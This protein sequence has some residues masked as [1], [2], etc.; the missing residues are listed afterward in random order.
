MLNSPLCP[1]ETGGILGGTNGVI[2]H[3]V[4]DRGFGDYDQYIPD[5]ELLNRIIIQ[6]AERN[7]SLMGIYHTHFVGC[8]ELSNGD[9]RYI[10]RI[11]DSA[12]EGSILYFPIVIPNKSVIAYRA[13]KKG[14]LSI[15]FN[16]IKTI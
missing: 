6:W 2:N 7:I 5:T 8:T 16:K 3:I 10:S 12:G 9:M 11:M 1:P 14:S 15:L 4:P 13:E